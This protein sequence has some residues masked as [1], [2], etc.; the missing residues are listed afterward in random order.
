MDATDGA[1]ESGLPKDL[2]RHVRR[3][4]RASTSPGRHTASM[5]RSYVDSVS[6]CIE[7]MSGLVTPQRPGQGAGPKDTET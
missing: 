4:N 1:M 2:C 6:I 7:A 5:I 3:R